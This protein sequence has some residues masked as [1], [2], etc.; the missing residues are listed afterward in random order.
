MIVF[1]KTNSNKIIA[2]QFNG[3]MNESDLPKLNWLL[4]G[5]KLNDEQLSGAFI[6]PRAAMVSPWSTNAVEI[7]QNMAIENI[8]RIEEYKIAKSTSDFYDPMLEMM[9]ETL[10]QDIFTVDVQPEKV[11][12][13]DDIAA[14]NQQEGLALSEDEVA[15]LQNVSDRVGRKLT[16]SEVFGF[17]QVNS[18]HCRHKIFNGTFVIDGQ[19]KPSSLFNLIRKTSNQNPN[20]IVSAYKDNVSFVKGPKAMQFAPISQNKADFFE[21]KDIDTV[22]S[23]KAETH[24]FPTTVEPFNGAATGSG[25]EIRD[26]MA[27]GQGSVPMAGTAVYMTS[28]SRLEENRNWENGMPARDWLYQSPIEILI[29]ASN[30]ASDFGNKFGQPL[31]NGSLL[32]FEHT[33]NGKKYGYDKVIMQAGGIGYGKFQDALKHVP[34]KGDKI[35]V[36]GGD[37]YR[38]GMGGSAVSSV[39]TG[40]FSSSIELNAIQRSNPEMQKRACNAV[41]AF[42][43]STTNP[44]ISIHDHGAGGHLNCLSEL[45]EEVGGTINLR[46]LPV[47][48]PTLSAKEIVGN[49]SQERMGLVIKQEDIALMQ[50]I[51]ERERSPMYVVG[52]IT[53]DH[54]FKFE[55]EQTGEDPIDLK[56][57]DMFGSPPKTVITDKHVAPNFDGLDYDN[58][59]IAEYLKQVLQLEAVACKDWLTN[60]VDR[61][62]TGKVAKQQTA[63]EIQL[64]LNNLGVVALD[65]KGEAGIATALGHAP[66]VALSCPKDG[67]K[68]AIAEALT[69]LIWAPL[70]DGIKSVSLSANWMWPCKNEGEDARL[71]D[72]VEAVSDFACDLGINIPTGKDSLSM[73]QK[74][75]DEK[76]YSPGTVII[77][78]S[79]EVSDVR[80]VVEP[81]LVNDE[82]TSLLLVDFSKDK[83]ELG[84]STF[85]QVINKVGDATPTISDNEYFVNAFNAVQNLINQGLVLAGHD[86]SAGGLITTLLEMNF[87]NAKGGLNVNFGSLDEKDLVK[88]LFSEIS[89][90]VIQV[91]DSSKVLSELGK[92]GVHGHVIGAPTAERT[93]AIKNHGAELNF[94]IDEMRDVWYKTSYLLDKKQS[95]EKLAAERFETYKKNIL[96]YKFPEG[97]TGKLSDYA[98][99]HGRQNKTGVKA[100][101]IR[102]KGVNGDREMAY[103]LFLAG[104]DVKDVHMTDL[105]AGREDLSDVNM[106]VFVGGFSN[107]DVLGSAK[108]W[109]GAFLYN[110]K[111]KEALDN[112]YTRPD[113]LSLGVCNG[114]QLMMELGLVKSKG[115]TQ[116]MHHN[117]SYKFESG[118]L[119]VEVPGNNSVMLNSLAGSKLGIWVAHGEGRFL[120]EGDEEEYNITMKYVDSS[121]PANPNSSEYNA[122]GLCS[123]DGRHLAMMPHLERII[124][125]WQGAHY[126]TDRKVDDVTPWFEA[127]VNARKWV[128]NK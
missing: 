62:V 109:A 28:Y 1:F 44:I 47:G 112:F 42:C 10:G 9:F 117:K 37:N 18:E 73:V 98:V 32:T 116:P 128:E 43:E 7:T 69:N 40:E 45:V 84:G 102:E 19:E 100:A 14:Y 74:Y 25:G 33:E 46:S 110:P 78:A 5:E 68:M 29:K 83:F 111:A 92:K 91:K 63:G 115:E 124:F 11:L 106:I 23:L 55:D 97:F 120:F 38:I 57:E 31:I 12:Y 8:V 67:S 3:E 121:Y 127:F 107:S 93:I 53:G 59:K 85:A 72:A 90:V 81:V 123:D 48:D 114:C 119:N 58:S 126:A 75:N 70:A 88:I 80:K 125:P 76:V 6:G 82:N 39:D 104:F 95:T 41:R 122:A 113:T 99:E 13:I 89:A 49:E 108:G 22:L 52:D 105:I 17:S 61:S 36:L 64:P 118:Y 65:F 27:G 24:N 79:G 51:C 96:N 54:N 30:G 34:E 60:K 86:V 56:I 21:T 16:D 20:T 26:R 103:S 87:A 77:T 66:A 4:D 15:Y 35:V 94:D 2:V 101:I 71:Y 50:E